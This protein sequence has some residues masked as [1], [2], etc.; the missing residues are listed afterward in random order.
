VKRFSL[1]AAVVSVVAAALILGPPGRA[2]NSA[3]ALYQEPSWSPNGRLIALISSHD[4]PNAFPDVYVMNA[5]G[6]GMRRVTHGQSE[7]PASDPCGH[8]TPAW[9]PSGKRLAYQAFAFLDAINLDGTHL[10]RLW[11]R[12]GANRANSEG[13]GGQIWLVNADSTGKRRLVAPPHAPI[14]FT[15]PSWSPDGKRIAFVYGIEPHPPKY[16]ES[17]GFIGVVRAD[18]R[19]RLTKLKAGG[20]PWQPAW[21]HDGRKIAFA[22]H[23]RWIAVLDLRTHRVR[24]LRRGTKPSWSPNGRRIAFQGPRGGIFVMNADGSHLRELTPTNS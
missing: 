5:D 24:R 15:Y 8:G 10:D 12:A 20:D 23:L 19:G 11:N 6:S 14:T 9:S 16:G 3:S 2:H 13:A 21:S 17:T 18:G 4:N 1:A 7:C 22:D